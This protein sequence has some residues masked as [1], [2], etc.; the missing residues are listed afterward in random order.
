M[1]LLALVALVLVLAPHSVLAAGPI[2]SGTTVAGSIGGPSYL[3]TWTFSGTAG[4][5][6]IVTA[7]TTSGGLNTSIVLKQP[8][9]GAIEANTNSGDRLDWQL[10]A[11]GT[12]TI[13]VR[14][15]NV[16][17]PAVYEAYRNKTF[18]IT[19]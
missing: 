2:T 11:T 14:A 3:E 8:V 17:S 9:G 7:I 4:N 19:Q 13:Q 6:I 18:I 15:R 16:G 12:Y 5:R 1:R 10:A